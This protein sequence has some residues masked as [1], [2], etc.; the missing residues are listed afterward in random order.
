M[1]KHQGF[2]I[3]LI[4]SRKKTKKMI[5]KEDKKGKNKTIMRE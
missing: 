1:K 4:D 2:L 5:S 3:N